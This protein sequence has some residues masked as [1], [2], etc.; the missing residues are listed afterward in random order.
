ML[1]ILQVQYCT[2]PGLTV[3]LTLKQLDQTGQSEP[4]SESTNDLVAFVSGLLLGNNIEVKNW[5]SQ[6]I[7]SGQ[8][9]SVTRNCSIFLV[10]IP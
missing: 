6:F 2:M 1:F 3:A 4:S 7:K 9:V 10:T 5:F 8:R